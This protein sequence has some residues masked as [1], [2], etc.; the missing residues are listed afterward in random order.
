MGSSF[1]DRLDELAHMVGNGDLVGTVE[2]SQIYAAYQLPSTM[3]WTSDIQEAAR[4]STSRSRCSRRR[5]TT[6]KATPAR[7]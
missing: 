2:V 5:I 3:G 7:S 1:S 6:S 4:R